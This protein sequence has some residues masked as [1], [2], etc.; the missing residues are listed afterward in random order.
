MK[1]DLNISKLI[2]YWLRHKPSEVGL[3]VDEFGWVNLNGLVAG[4]DFYKFKLLSSQVQ[5]RASNGTTSVT[6]ST[7][8]HPLKK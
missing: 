5:T 8:D 7:I 6:N 2:S 4:H 1:H 3:E